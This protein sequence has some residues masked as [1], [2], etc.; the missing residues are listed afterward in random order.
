[1][2]AIIPS[3]CYCIKNNETLKRALMYSTHI[4]RKTD[5]S[6]IDFR[7]L[8]FQIETEKEKAVHAVVNKLRQAR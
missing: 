3:P 6:D 1:M 8:Q 5:N 7:V 4:K 2:S